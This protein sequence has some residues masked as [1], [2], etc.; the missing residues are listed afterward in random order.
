MDTL[1][2]RCVLFVKH[3]S[4]G[5]VWFGF[6]GKNCFIHGSTDFSMPARFWCR[7]SERPGRGGG[8]GGSFLGLALNRRR[9][10]RHSGF[11]FHQCGIM[12]SG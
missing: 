10:P 9:P 8:G 2:R 1:V 7:D 3:Y 12:A 11:A 4:R 5:L 6:T